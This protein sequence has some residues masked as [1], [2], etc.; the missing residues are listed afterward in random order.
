MFDPPRCPNLDCPRH[1]HP[2]GRFYWR[3][4][5]FRA[6]CRPWPVPRFQC[7]TCGRRFSRQTFR[8]DYRDHKPHLNVQVFS[9]L[10][11]GSGLR[12]TARELGLTKRNLEL[13]FRKL[14]RHLAALHDN[15]ADGIDGVVRLAFDEMESFEGCRSTRPVTIPFLIHQDTMFILASKSA[16]IR[17]SGKMT[18][19]RRQRIA[20]EEARHGRRPNGS[21][22]VC[23]EVLEFAAARCRSARWIELRSDKKKTYVPIAKR[24]FGEQRLFHLRIDSKRKR[25]V[26][27]PLH[28]INL[29]LAIARDLLGRLHR[30]SWLVTKKREFLDLH[31]AMVRCYRNYH[32]PRF[33]KDDDSPAQMLGLLPRRMHQE[34]LLSWRQDWGAERSIHPLSPWRES[35]AEYQARMRVAG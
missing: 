9:R 11:S 20:L 5:S 2:D 8:A 22:G 14:G 21:P 33:N 34:E 13:K 7:R 26:F 4:G 28:R 25:D 10:C 27:N 31:L 18:P 23:K 32:R 16:P 15:L 12:Q 19:A 30:R 24:A 35:V 29:T 3:K 6:Q 1:R 17:P